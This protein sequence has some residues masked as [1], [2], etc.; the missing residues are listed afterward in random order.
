ME[1][2]SRELLELE[3]KDPSSSA[4][5]ALLICGNGRKLQEEKPKPDGKPFTEPPPKSQVLDRVKGFL[6]VISEANRNLQLNAEGKAQD[7]NIEVL[8]GD[9]SEYI[10]MDLMLGVADLHTPEAVSA[11]EAAIA[12]KQSVLDLPANVSSSESESSS[13][14]DDDDDEDDDN[15]DDED[16]RMKDG[17]PTSQESEKK[18]DSSLKQR[19]KCGSKSKRPKIVELS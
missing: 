2:R 3:H 14:D 16:E 11:A 6:G 4:E 18:E 5:A 15:D 8:K 7:Y 17:S 9:E 12:G 1:K 13:D 10:Q 19:T